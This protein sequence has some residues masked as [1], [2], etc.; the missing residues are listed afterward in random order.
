MNELN[1]LIVYATAM[2]PLIIAFL[3]L[4]KAQGLPIKLV[5][6]AS[7]ITGLSGMVLINAAVEEI[8]WTLYQTL[9][10]GV[11]AAMMAGGFYSGTKAVFGSD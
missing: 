8:D 11:V 1:D 9:F 3:Q 5:P 10:A 2:T 6:V 7:I 4:L